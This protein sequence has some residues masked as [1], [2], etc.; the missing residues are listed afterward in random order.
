LLLPNEITKV[1]A[2]FTPLKKKEY[3]INVPVYA[4]NVYDTLRD[5]IGFYNPGSGQMQRHGM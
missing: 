4:S 1:I 3:V 5:L 2:T